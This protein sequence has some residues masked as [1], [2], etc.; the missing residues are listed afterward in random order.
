MKDRNDTLDYTTMTEDWAFEHDPEFYEIF[1][2]V[3]TLPDKEA[4]DYAMD[5]VKR[6]AK[7]RDEDCEN[8]SGFPESFTKEVFEDWTFSVKSDGNGIFVGGAEGGVGAA[9]VFLQHLLQKYYPD[10]YLA[11]EWSHSWGGGAAVITAQQI[12]FES[13][14]S[15]LDKNLPRGNGTQRNEW[16][17]R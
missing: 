9:G 5:L 16:K 15:W 11:F 3:I 2:V 17:S 12:K 14:A 13:T 8:V 10:D 1:R 4:V 6:T 7:A